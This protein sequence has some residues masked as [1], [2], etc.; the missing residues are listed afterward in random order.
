MG[1][2][3]RH[4]RLRL[5][6][7]NTRRASSQRPRSN[8]RLPRGRVAGG[9]YQDVRAACFGAGLPLLR[10]H[11]TRSRISRGRRAESTTAALPVSSAGSR[12]SRVERQQKSLEERG[13]PVFLAFCSGAAAW[14]FAISFC[15]PGAPFRVRKNQHESKSH[16]S[17][18]RRRWLLGGSA[19]ATR[20]RHP[21]R[22]YEGVNG[23][24]ERG[25]RSL[26]RRGHSSLKSCRRS[27][28]TRDL[29]YA[30]SSSCRLASF[31]SRWS[32]PAFR[33]RFPWIGTV[34]RS[35]RP[36]FPYTWWLPRIEMR[37]QPCRSS[38]E[39]SFFPEMN[40]TIS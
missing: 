32:S 37:R 14:Y 36:S 39:A 29:A 12:R 9:R 26:A 27:G 11:R 28:R 20:L 38:A 24:R 7:R 33:S 30:R 19:R 3:S 15:N 31:K 22:R 1:R 4:S 40:F 25:D 34:I 13:S 5:A 23:E 6:G 10:E 8:R 35:R 18:R 17:S 2:S 21:G 16:H